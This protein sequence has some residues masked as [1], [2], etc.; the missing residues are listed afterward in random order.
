MQRVDSSFV[1]ARVTVYTVI[2]LLI[3][4]V[5]T[6]GWTTPIKAPAETGYKLFRSQLQSVRSLILSPIDA[7]AERGRLR[8]R[9]VELEQELAQRTLD[10]AEHHRV[11]QENQDLRQ[12][13]QAPLPADWTYAVAPVLGSQG[14]LVVLGVGRSDQVIVGDSVVSQDN[15]LGSL[16]S[17]SEAISLMQPLAHPS[18]RIAASV[19]AQGWTGGLVIYK[20]EELLLTQ[21]LQSVNLQSG[22]LVMTSGLD[23]FPAGLVL[24]VVSSIR[25]DAAGLYKEAVIKQNLDWQLAGNL[26][27][28]TGRQSETP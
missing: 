1:T 15:M 16:V 2:C 19:R 11:L 5:D 9:V 12:L 17:V 22:Q 26:F 21:V 24:G 14:P 20:G 28:I 18:T 7:I 25:T 3:L 4:L 13:V 27:V 23:R 8:S 10:Q 6:I